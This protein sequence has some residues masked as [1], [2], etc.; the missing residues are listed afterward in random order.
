[1][2]FAVDVEADQLAGKLLDAPKEAMDLLGVLAAN[3]KAVKEIAQGDCGSKF[4]Q[5]VPAFLRELAAYLD[6]TA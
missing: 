5:A 3:P 4:H 6:S 2:E 1:M